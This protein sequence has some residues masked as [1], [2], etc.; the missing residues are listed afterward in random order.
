MKAELAGRSVVISLDA[1]CKMGNKHIPGDPHEISDNGKIME[2]V[3]AR[4]ALTVANGLEGKAKGVI[5]R[6]RT[7]TERVEQSAIDL[8]CLSRDLVEE[9]K[10]VLIDEDKN[11]VLEK[12]EKTKQRRVLK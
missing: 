8:V 4:H 5:T 12:I 3:L 7:T 10:S 2:G 11:Y 1:N 6:K 9:T